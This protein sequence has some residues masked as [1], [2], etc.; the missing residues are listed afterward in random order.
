MCGFVTVFQRERLFAPSILAAMESDILHR[1]PDSGGIHSE[2]G[3]A[4]VFRRLAILDPGARS[5]QPMTDPSGS[6]TLVFNGEIYNYKPL[7]R[8]LEQAGC[9]LQTTGDTEV[10]V[11]GYLTWGE[12]VVDRLEGMFAFVLLDRNARKVVAARDPLGIKPLYVMRHGGMTAF[13]SEMRPLA[14][15]VPVDP[16]CQ[17]LAELLTFRFAAGRLSNLR[18]VE[19]LPGGTVA[20]LSPESG[21]LIERRFCDPLDTL[22]PEETLTFEKA[23]EETDAA[24]R[25]SVVAHLQSDVGYAIQLSG[26]VDSSLIAALAKQE[27]KGPVASFGV[28]LDDPNYD[29]SSYRAAVVRKCGL[30]HHEVHLTGIDFAD[31]LPRAVRHMEGPVP[32]YGCVMLMLLCDRIRQTSKVV[33]TG[34]GGD[35]FFGGY[36]RYELWK[37]LKHKG[38]LA[39]LV[40]GP[41]WPMLQ[42]YRE[43]RRYSGRDPAIYAAV[44]HDF[45]TLH[46]VF[47]D[48]LPA[49]GARDVAAARFSDFRSRMFAADQTAYLESLLMRQDKMA[50]AAS[51]EARVPY[52]HMPLI[53]VINRVPHNIR[54]PGG[55]TKPLLKEIA[56]RYVPTEIVRR[57]KIGLTLPL[58]QWAHDPAGLG[59][60]LD[61]VTATDSQ[62]AA[63][64]DRKRLHGIVDAFRSGTL[65][66][67]LLIP[68]LINMELWLRSLPRHDLKA[69]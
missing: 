58:D 31:A 28:K 21:E 45:L 37:D 54:V 10:I 4:F 65:R 26:G 44:Y 51:V 16:D 60:Y 33:L 42:R 25:N 50:M 17:A 34:E 7:R 67:T 64:A 63:F 6:C 22:R 48:V 35:E 32:H 38:R 5:D 69:A 36:K 29:E 62:L 57:R 52:V 3:A 39:A 13:T 15:L 43:I 20:T 59:R 61:L 24:I 14:R 53:R 19:K 11:Q 55:D 66:S 30:D 68:H 49:P 41:L 1:G 8:E 46:E 2:P 18:S 47:P 9:R 40:P 27:A 23:V 56:E 12:A